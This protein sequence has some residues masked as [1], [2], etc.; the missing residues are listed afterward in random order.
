MKNILLFFCI[1]LIQNVNSQNVYPLHPSVGDT[2]DVTEKLDYS[3]FPEIENSGFQYATIQFK[4][5]KFILEI[6][7]RDID[8]ET[9]LE[10]ETSYGQDLSQEKIIEEQQKIQKI[11][12]YYKYLAEE[13]T[14]PKKQ[15]TQAI[16]KSVPIR[17]EGAMSEKMK[18]E[19]RMNLRLKEDSRRMQE[20]EM[21]LRPREVRIE[22]N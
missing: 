17:F 5:N 14:K 18:K 20:F 10:I 12:A 11:N 3:L 6:V 21:G 15:P 16:Q 8:K 9:G 1:L 7:E 13:A 19:A 22:F 2:I 4:K